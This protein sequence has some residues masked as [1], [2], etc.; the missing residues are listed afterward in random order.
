MPKEK[1]S[2][3]ARLRGYVKEFGNVFC[4]DGSLLF[5]TACSKT[6][7]TE[8]KSQVQQH[9][10]SAKHIANSQRKSAKQQSFSQSIS[11][12][13]EGCVSLGSS[14]SSLPDEFSLEL[15]KALISADIPLYAVQ[16]AT[17]RSFLEKYCNRSIPDESTLRKNYLHIAYTQTLTKIRNSVR[18]SN[19]WISVDES[20]DATGRYVANF[21]VGVLSVEKE[22]SRN[23]FLLHSDALEKSDHSSIAKFV[24]N[25][26]NILWPDELHYNRVLLFVSDAAAY[27]LKAVRGLAV[28]FP[29]MRHLTCL[30]HG[31]HRVAETVRASFPEVDKLVS[32]VKKIFKKSPHRRMVFKEMAPN[33]KHP[34]E[35]VLTRWGT[36][37]KA[38]QY[39]CDNW[40]VVKDVVSQFDCNSATAIAD[41]QTLF[42]KDSVR[43][44]LVCISAHFMG[45][46]SVIEKL[47]CRCQ[48]LEESLHTIK[49]FQQDLQLSTAPIAQACSEKL[50]SVLKKNP[51]Y[52][53][54]CAI[55]DIIRGS[56]VDMIE[57]LSA[58]EVLSFKYSPITS[59]DVERS[60]SKLKQVL[61]DKRRSLTM[62]HLTWILVT[63]CNA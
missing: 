30:A 42:Q 33:L 19:I 37:L 51:A 57:G 25:S 54:L 16:N 55:S 48:P 1:S 44:N 22:E 34:P 61:S 24:I 2:T 3:A 18:D 23:C 35:P 43:A 58:A 14:R 39:Y 4:V 36:W 8:R 7:A 53:D 26:L 50:L 63:L 17:F 45:L 47:E 15:C 46:P 38:V 60:F 12:Q 32:S 52:E 31:L 13:N 21:I 6:V 49:N 41:A 40:Q 29:K 62:K 27:M 9:M 28:L 10:K 59:C 56:R 11:I 5:C 20:T